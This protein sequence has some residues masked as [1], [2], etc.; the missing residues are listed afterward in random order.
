MGRGRCCPI[1][2]RL[3]VSRD[4]EE[5]VGAPLGMPPKP[6]SKPCND[7]LREARNEFDSGISSLSQPGLRQ[8]VTRH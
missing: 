5:Q 4:V 8:A 6:S 7:G 1:N 2:L 3:G